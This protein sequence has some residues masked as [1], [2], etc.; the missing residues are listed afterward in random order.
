MSVL[1]GESFGESDWS[2]MTY[3]HSAPSG[4]CGLHDLFLGLVLGGELASF[5]SAGSFSLLLG[6]LWWGLGGILQVVVRDCQRVSAV[7]EMSH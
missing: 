1:I 2:A 4:G 7:S 5:L 3:W 6:V